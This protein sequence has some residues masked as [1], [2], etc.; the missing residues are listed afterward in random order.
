MSNVTLSGFFSGIDTS[1]IISQLMALNRIPVTQLQSQKSSLSDQN[2]A[3]GF[4]K[5]SLSTL[6]SKLDALNDPALF[7]SRK[8]T[9]SSANVG[10]VS[11]TDKASA[12][13]TKI[14]VIKVATS[15][16]VSSGGTKATDVSSGS[17]MAKDVWGSGVLGKFSINNTQ[18]TITESTTI[19]DIVNMI[20][21]VPEID[22]SATVYDAETGKFTISATGNLI[23]GTSGDTS[24]FFQ[25]TQLFNG[26]VVDGGAGKIVTSMLGAGRIDLSQSIGDVENFG[27]IEGKINGDGVLTV[28]GVDIAYSVS[29][30]VSTLLSRITSS[31]AGVVA[32]Y[33][34]YADQF[35]ITATSRGAQGISIVDKTGNLAQA[36]QLRTGIDTNVILGNSTQFKVND[37]ETRESV[38]AVITE[39]ESG[40][41]G[42]TFTPLTAGTT[43]I[44]VGAD[45]DKIKKV[46]DDFVS[47]YNSAQNI[48]ESYVKVD[49]SDPTKNGI[50]ASDT[51]FA[52]LA[53][54]LRSSAMS[55]LRGSGSIRMLEDLGITGNGENN[56]V[57]SVDASKLENA[58]N[59]HLDEIIDL[60]ANATAGLHARLNPIVESYSSS[61]NGSLKNRQESISKQQKFIDDEIERLEAR[62]ELERTYLETQFAAMEQYSAQSQRF[63]QFFQNFSKN[64]S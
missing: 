54:S 63:S 23:L 32:T 56:T 3:V 57:T 61:V 40:V 58:L 15:S 44:T 36:M 12:G 59:Q 64:N 41:A 45:V 55:Q 37:G 27:G 1:S 33:D 18:L 42:L 38:D 13:T 47:Q 20:K 30:S 6:Q 52:F 51:A 14:Q 19:E 35:V 50:L 11:V 29:D 31:N 53:S 25:A 21:T 39:E 46:I 8:A 62:L 10:T 22:A 16:S 7:R 24:N 4:I 60:F 5:S 2:S 43:T 48:I 34:S 9:L 26:N 28:N 49:T 17:A